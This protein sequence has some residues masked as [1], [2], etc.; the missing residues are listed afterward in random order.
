MGALIVEKGQQ[1]DLSIEK[2]TQV[3]KWAE[4]ESD[5]MSADVGGGI[6]DYTKEKYEQPD[7][8]FEEYVEELFKNEVNDVG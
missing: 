3:L 2:F 7:P 4:V 8:N 1:P 5:R 6:G